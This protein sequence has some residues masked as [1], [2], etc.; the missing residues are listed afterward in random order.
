MP[1]KIRLCQEWK[2]LIVMCFREFKF[3]IL[4][5]FMHFLSLDTVTAS[6][7]LHSVMSDHDGRCG[8]GTFKLLDTCATALVI[9]NHSLV[10]GE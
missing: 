7:M 8:C 10:A 3:I 1:G 6:I 5:F 4:D 2:I 9:C